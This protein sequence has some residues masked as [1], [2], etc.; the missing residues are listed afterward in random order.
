[1]AGLDTA[2]NLLDLAGKVYNKCCQYQEDREDVSYLAVRI[3]ILIGIIE[4]DDFLQESESEGSTV[5]RQMI[6][7][8][9]KRAIQNANSFIEDFHA[10]GRMKRMVKAGYWASRSQK[11]SMEFNDLISMLGMNSDVRQLR[12]LADIQKAIGDR[13]K[14]EKRTRVKELQFLRLELSKVSY[15]PNKDGTYVKPVAATPLQM[16]HDS[17]V[18]KGR[19][20]NQT[21][22]TKMMTIST[23]SGNTNIM[24]SAVGFSSGDI[25]IS[26]D[27]KLSPNIQRIFENPK[28]ACM[29][30]DEQHLTFSVGKDDP[31]G[32]FGIV[33]K[34]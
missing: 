34:G 3:S 13:Q 6:H 31:S 23:R 9:L 8:Q 15:V 17:V 16:L 21:A 11:L 24:S 28:Y 1:M 2:F 29:F 5:G 26:S 12:M 4:N 18:G 19:R 30:L 14:S 20:N 27:D 7:Q 33:H 32:A 22:S 10:T 25:Y